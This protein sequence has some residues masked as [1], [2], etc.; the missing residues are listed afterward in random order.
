MSYIKLQRKQRGASLIQVALGLLVLTISG[1][2]AFNQYQELQTSNRNNY[3]FE[4][5]SQWLGS[6]TNIG[7]LNAHVYTGLD[8]DTVVDQTSIE[9]T[10][11][12][13]GLAI[14]TDIVTSNWQ[15]TFPFPDAV[16]CEYVLT[17]VVDHPGLASTAPTCN[18]SN[19]LVA[20]V[21]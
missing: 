21:E 4:E 9:D 16:A 19:E 6:M 11:N 13:Y 3:A 15:L 7:S 8:A 18:A 1:V 5:T 2:F 14:S 20:V 12:I 17:R 10:T